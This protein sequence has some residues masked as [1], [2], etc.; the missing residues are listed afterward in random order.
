MISNLLHC[1]IVFYNAIILLLWV[2]TKII[3]L[4]GLSLCICIFGFFCVNL[5][6]PIYNEIL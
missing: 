5:S 3:L 6:W 1:Y 4:K 2:L